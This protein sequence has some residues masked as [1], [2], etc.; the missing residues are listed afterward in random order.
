MDFTIEELSMNAWPSIQTV[1]YDGWIIRLANGYTKRANSI[2]PI[3]PSKINLEE[4]IQHCKN[5]YAKYNLPVVYKLVKCDEHKTI[6]KKLEA[7]NYEAL[8]ITSVQICD[9][10]KILEENYPGINIHID[11]NEKWINGFIKNNNIKGEFIETLKTMLKNIT[12]NKIVV[13]KELNNEVA[14]CGYGVIENEYVGLFD[15]VIK[16]DKRG[17]GYGKEIVQS[18]LSEA[19][20]AGI[21]KSYLQVVN[22]NEIAKG[23]YKKIG[24]KEKYTYWYR[25]TPPS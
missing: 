18:I 1:V 21:K 10:I 19:G 2:N 6:D 12:G 22:N 3:Y 5:L 9:D 4:K 25:K 16:E 11:F 15:I 20:K 17:R 14:G 7:L 23:L 13:Y 24:Y 8:D